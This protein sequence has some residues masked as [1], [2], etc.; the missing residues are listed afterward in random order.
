[1]GWDGNIKRKTNH[2]KQSNFGT[3]NSYFLNMR[4]G[5]GDRKLFGMLKNATN[6]YFIKHTIIK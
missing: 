4:M 2:K 3:S 1:M 5:W 6:Y